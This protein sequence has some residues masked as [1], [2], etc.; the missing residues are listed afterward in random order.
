MIEAGGDVAAGDAVLVCIRPEDVTIGPPADGGLTSA[1]NR[2][3]AT[4]TRLTPA[5]PWVRV[6]LDAGFPLV[7][8]ITKRS[9]EELSLAPGAKAV[10]TLKATAVHLIQRQVT[11][12]G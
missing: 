6:E 3:P 10:A 8:L 2:L 9:V 5:G 12:D 7:A 4:V 11:G 1:R